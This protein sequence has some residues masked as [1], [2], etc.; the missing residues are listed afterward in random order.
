M[1]IDKLLAEREKAGNPI[2]VG[3]VGAGVTG[4]MISLQL[5][6]STPGI[7]LVAISNRTLEKGAQAFTEAGMTNFEPVSRVDKLEDRI[8]A[9]NFSLVDD[10]F[11]LCEAANIDIILDVTGTVEFGAELALKAIRYGKHLVLV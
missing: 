11:L 2:R 3:L 1:N 6:T 10:P 7:K 8:A 9:G 5:L 4:R